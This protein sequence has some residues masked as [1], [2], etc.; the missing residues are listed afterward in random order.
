M[1]D[2]VLERLRQ[3]D[4]KFIDRLGHLVTLC[5]NKPTRNERRKESEKKFKPAVCDK[6]QREPGVLMSP[7]DTSLH[8]Q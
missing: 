1:P 7:H 8:T 3:K 6:I 2:T 4:Q 5:L